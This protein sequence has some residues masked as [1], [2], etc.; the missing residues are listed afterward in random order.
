[1]LNDIRR[2]IGKLKTGRRELR[3]FGILFFVVPGLIAALRCWRGHAD[4]PFFAAPAALFLLAG[5]AAP[6][7][8][9]PLYKA[10]MAFAIVLGWVM[11]RVLLTL[12]FFLIFT[13]MGFLTKIMGKDLLDQKWAPDAET[14][15]KKHDPVAGRER[16]KKP[17]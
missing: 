17:Y 8:L 5:L 9:K 11:T 4:W 1:M 14:Y 12:T 16:Y 6:G 15:W 10:W 2:E 7:V 13:P 3:N